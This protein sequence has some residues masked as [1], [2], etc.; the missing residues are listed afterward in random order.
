MS[1][2]PAATR[3]LVATSPN[4]SMPARSKLCLGVMLNR[5]MKLDKYRLRFEETLFE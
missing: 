5:F 1:Q 4:A 3:E 2:G